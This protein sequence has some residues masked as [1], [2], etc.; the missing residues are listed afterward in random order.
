VSDADGAPSDADRQ[1]QGREDTESEA[2]PLVP[3]WAHLCRERSGEGALGLRPFGERATGAEGEALESI[4]DAHLTLGIRMDPQFAVYAWAAT[5]EFAE[6]AKAAVAKSG[7]NGLTRRS[8]LT[9]G[10]PTLTTFD[11][12][13]MIGTTNSPQSILSPCFVL[14]Q[15]KDGKYVRETPAKKGTLDCNPKNAVSIKADDIDN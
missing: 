6:A 11:A 9:D 13:G 3:G 12:G 4:G 14:M 15:L 8:L 1:L 2:G 7:V 5:M 10:I